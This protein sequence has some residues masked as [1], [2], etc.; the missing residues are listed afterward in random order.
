[1]ASNGL[2]TRPLYLQVRDVLVERIAEGGWKPGAPIP[3]EVDLARE[4]G[5]STGTVR[6]ALNLMEGER[7][8]T[9]RQGRGT[10]VNDQTSAE[11]AARFTNI[12]APNG[13]RVA[14][15][16]QLGEINE[17]P[18]TDLERERLRLQKHETVYRI[19]C[20]RLHED[21]PF[22]VEESA[23]P[24]SLFPGL[25]KNNGFP[26]SIA[27]LAQQHGILLGKAEERVSAQVASPSVAEAL[28]VA[29]TAPILVLDRV[30]HALD[31]RPIEWRLG[32]CY[33]AEHCY[34]AEIR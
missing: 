8:I 20:V 23:M 9:R 30:L 32:Q 16:V 17:S 11:L 14:G 34:L 6:N 25:V 5:V 13:K 21:R 10:F 29:P 27:D 18:A 1:M 4:Y 28:R 2:L 12:R 15:Q 33:L 7:L 3:N 26:H 31:G 24:V 19:R 22:M